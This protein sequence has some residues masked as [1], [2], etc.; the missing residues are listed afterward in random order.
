[1]K[2][3]KKTLGLCYRCRFQFKFMYRSSTGIETLGFTVTDK[4]TNERRKKASK[5]S[6]RKRS[7][8]L[9]PINVTVDCITTHVEPLNEKNSENKLNLRLH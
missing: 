7:L 3:R 8:T 9:I 6:F 5:P 4:Q 2:Q 1:M